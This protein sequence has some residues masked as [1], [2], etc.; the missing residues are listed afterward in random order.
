MLQVKRAL[1]AEAQHCSAVHDFRAEHVS[2][3]NA[4]HNELHLCSTCRVAAL[5]TLKKKNGRP[6]EGA[7]VSA[8]I[9]KGHD[10]SQKT[11]P[12]KTTPDLEKNK[13]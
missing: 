4:M 10:P 6:G 3:D 11:K 13:N 1:E 7:K 5:C 12:D 2:A 8:Q 9:A